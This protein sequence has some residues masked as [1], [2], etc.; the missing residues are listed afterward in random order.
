MPRQSHASEAQQHNGAAR[1]RG[2]FVTEGLA[3]G[4]RGSLPTRVSP[5]N[6]MG[7]SLRG[8]AQVPGVVAQVM[9][10]RC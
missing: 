3:A 8:V 4:A 10:G 1:L 7:N 5:R 9:G 6:R 2:Q